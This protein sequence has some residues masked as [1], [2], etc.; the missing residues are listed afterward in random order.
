MSDGC[1]EQYKNKKNFK[2]LCLH[3]KDFGIEADWHFFPTSHGKG[4]CDGF[5]GTIK[6]MA[7]DDSKRGIKINDAIGFYNWAYNNEKLK[8]EWNFIWVSDEECKTTE[9]KKDTKTS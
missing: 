7:F 6:R 5:G 9:N 2:N 4:V 8:K 1:A 3:L